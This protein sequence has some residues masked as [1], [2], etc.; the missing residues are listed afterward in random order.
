MGVPI[1]RLWHLNSAHTDMQ[2]P[3]NRWL[4]VQKGFE[5][6][7]VVIKILQFLLIRQMSATAS[8]VDASQ[9]VLRIKPCGQDA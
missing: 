3:I 6:I 4:S 2:W 7:S 9:H 8:P 5:K 1:S